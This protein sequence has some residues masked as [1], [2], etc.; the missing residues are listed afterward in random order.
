M[1]IISHVYTNALLCG[2]SRKRSYHSNHKPSNK[3]LKSAAEVAWKAVT[4]LGG[5]SPPALPDLG[6]GWRSVTP[7]SVPC[8]V[9]LA[10]D[11]PHGREAPGRR[12]CSLKKEQSKLSL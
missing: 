2:V 12:I 8:S 5:L 4:Y 3:L 9:P 10:P 7:L 6:T 11:V 1:H